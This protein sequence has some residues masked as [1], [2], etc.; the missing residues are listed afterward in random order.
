MAMNWSRIS[1]CSGD[2]FL[3]WLLSSTK[4]AFRTMMIVTSRHPAIRKFLALCDWRKLRHGRL[5]SLAAVETS[6]L[7]CEK[8]D[9]AWA[10]EGTG[11]EIGY[12]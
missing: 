10:S 9:E 5:H 12:N 7:S 11:L 6:L 2:S 3:D 4:S 8:P 1:F